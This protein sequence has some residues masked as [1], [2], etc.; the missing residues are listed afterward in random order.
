M[1]LCKEKEKRF[2]S[3]LSEKF[4]SEEE[5]DIESI[6]ATTATLIKSKPQW[7]STG[8]VQYTIIFTYIMC[9]LVLERFISRLDERDKKK[10]RRQPKLKRI[11]SGIFVNCP[12]PENA[13]SWAI[14]SASVSTSLESAE[15]VSNVANL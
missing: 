15:V 9:V 13:L 4:M 10:N 5:T 7:R 3:K 2:W 8:C 14:R 1:K 6:T 12:I 11:D